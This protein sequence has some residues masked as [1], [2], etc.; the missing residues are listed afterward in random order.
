MERGGFR[1]KALKYIRV[2]TCYLHRSTM[3]NPSELFELSKKRASAGR[4]G[5]KARAAAL[6]KKERRASALKASKAAAK[7]RSAKAGRS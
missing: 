3:L 6:T 4:K 5:G 7:A 2:V 1:V